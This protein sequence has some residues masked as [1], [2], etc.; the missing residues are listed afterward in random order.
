M[1]AEAIA[2]DATP[3][4]VDATPRAVARRSCPLCEKP[5][6]A[7]F[8]TAA[9]ITAELSARDRFFAARLD[10]HLPHEALRDVTDVVLGAP[11]AI[12]RCMGCGMLIRDAVPGEGVFR[13]DRYVDRVLEVLHGTHVRAFQAKERDYRPLLPPHARVVEVGS[14]VGGFLST[15]AQWEWR[16]SGVDIGRDVLRFCRGLGLDVECLPFAECNLEASSLDAVF[17]W[18]CFE[19]LAEPMDVLAE[20]HR[21]LRA[22]GLLVIRVPDADFYIRGLQQASTAV[23]AYNGLLGWPHRFGYDA[24]NLCRLVQ[25]H[26]FAFVHAFRRPAVRPLREAMHPWAREEEARLI[27]DAEHGWIEATFSKH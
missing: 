4:A 23:L 7:V 19:Q 11:A 27:G 6:G 8:L 21:V 20:A 12:L 9:E 3:R 18:N 24:G 22:G 17:I 16:A 15:A 25:K 5:T 13:E 2:V 10:G 1:T 26:R 14:Y